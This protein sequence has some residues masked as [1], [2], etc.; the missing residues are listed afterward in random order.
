VIALLGVAMWA[1]APKGLSTIYKGYLEG[2]ASGAMV[3]SIVQAV[4]ESASRGFPS[5]N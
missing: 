5:N 4:G 1:G 3:F 2:R